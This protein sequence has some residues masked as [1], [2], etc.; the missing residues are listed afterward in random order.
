MDKSWISFLL[1]DD[2]YK[3]KKMLYFMAESAV[4]LAVALFIYALITNVELY[5]SSETGTL[6]GLSFVF[7]TGYV[8]VRYT[9]SG[10]EYTDIVGHNSYQKE[11]KTILFR[12]LMFLIT[13]LVASII[14]K[15]IPADM[16]ELLDLLGPSILAA[17]FMYF[18][19]YISLKRSY[20]KNK[21][22]LDD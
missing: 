5:G 2:E 18:W 7:L 12:S 6:A 1:P 9:F 14:L 17:V 19:N 15:G 10:I 22:L 21:D 16:E 8:L 13:F 11:K 3:E 20:Q 4:L